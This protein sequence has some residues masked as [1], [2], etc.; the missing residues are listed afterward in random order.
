MARSRRSSNRPTAIPSSIASRWL[1]RPIVPLS[2]LIELEDRRAYHPERVYRA[3][4]ASVRK[5]AQIVVKRSGRPFRFPDVLGFRQPRRVLLCVRRQM[6]KEVLFAH[7]RVRSGAGGRRRRNYW[8]G[9]S[10]K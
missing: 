4:R 2:P 8:S 3:P 9:I 1:V 5:A 6:R 7:R 10:C